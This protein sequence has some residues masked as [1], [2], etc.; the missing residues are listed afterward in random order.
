MT[1]IV[2]DNPTVVI[3]RIAYGGD[4]YWA[5]YHKH[6][7][8]W[9]IYLTNAR[10]DPVMQHPQKMG[11]RYEAIIAEAQKVYAMEKLTS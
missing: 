11:G 4:R 7:R 3:L 9:A 2:V 10:G 6:L 5:E 8:T 1:Q